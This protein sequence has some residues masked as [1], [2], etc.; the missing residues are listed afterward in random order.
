MLMSYGPLKFWGG[1]T[2]PQPTSSLFGQKWALSNWQ[3][4]CFYSVYKRS[5]LYCRVYVCIATAMQ[6]A[7]RM[8][9]RCDMRCLVLTHQ[10]FAMSRLTF[11][12]YGSAVSP[13]VRRGVR[14]AYRR[15][16]GEQL[17]V[18]LAYACICQRMSIYQRPV[19]P[20]VLRT[21]QR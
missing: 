11:P 20:V 13:S 8:H 14:E 12:Y 16:M 9:L 10:T 17:C 1:G 3:E 5:D 19:S 21:A 6:C 18:S 2:P 4:K 15:Y 7:L